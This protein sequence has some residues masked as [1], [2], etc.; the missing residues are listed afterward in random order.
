MKVWSQWERISGEDVF[1]SKLCFSDSPVLVPALKA[2]PTLGTKT[3][4]F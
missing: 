1:K 4:Y 2:P 3:K